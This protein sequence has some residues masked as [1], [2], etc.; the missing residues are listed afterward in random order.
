VTQ[1]LI[2]SLAVLA[3]FLLGGGGVWMIVRRGDRQKGML[4]IFT[5][6]VLLGNV[7]IIA[8]P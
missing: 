1:S 2:L 3:V 7:L 6:I 4:M 8:A 5:A